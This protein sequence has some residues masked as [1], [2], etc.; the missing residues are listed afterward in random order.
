M[1][2]IASQVTNRCN[3]VDGLVPEVVLN[4][5]QILSDNNHY[6]RNLKTAKEIFEQH[7]NPQ[8]IKVVINEERRPSGKHAKRYNSPL[9]MTLHGILMS[10]DNTHNRDIALHYRNSTLVHI[11]EL[12]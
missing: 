6:I 5:S 1:D 10:N 9:V 4:I 8:S 12:H 3:V 11:S 2:N 7:S